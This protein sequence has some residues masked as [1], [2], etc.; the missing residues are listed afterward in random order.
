MIGII[1]KRKGEIVDMDKKQQAVNDLY[2]GVALSGKLYSELTEEENAKQIEAI[3]RSFGY[4]PEEI[5]E[6]A[7]MGLGCGN[8]LENANVV[9]GEVV[10]DLGCGK[11]MDT[12]IA[13]KKV[14][15][16][17][18][19]IGVDRLSEMVE[20]AKQISDKRGFTNTTFIQSDID[21]I[22]LPDETADCIISNCVINLVEDKLKVY[23]EIFRLLKPGGR[24]S[25]SDIVLYNPLPG[26]IADDPRLHAT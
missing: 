5:T 23:Q 26:E 13:S 12:F 7:N 11:G 20:R 6:E 14:G 9:E 16:S 2:A 25:I 4:D 10:V 24:I 1:N 8:P 17:G 19:A 3:S 15:S 18:R 22:D 21:D